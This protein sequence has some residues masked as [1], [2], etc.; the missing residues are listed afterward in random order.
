MEDCFLFLEVEGLFLSWDWWLRILFWRDWRMCWEGGAKR[1]WGWT[2]Q[3]WERAKRWRVEECEEEG[4]GR[5]S[6][7]AMFGGARTMGGGRGWG[8]VFLCFLF[9]EGGG[10]GGRKCG[11]ASFVSHSK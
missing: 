2:D 10:G 3:I 6:K 1:A 8:R 7:G 9:L 5:R 4:M 11:W